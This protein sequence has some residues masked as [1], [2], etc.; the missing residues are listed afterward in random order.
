VH[1][2]QDIRVDYEHTRRLVR[3]LG[4]AGRPP[5][6]LYFEGEGHGSDDPANLRKTWDGVAGFL[7]QHLDGAS[8]A[9]AP[10]AAAE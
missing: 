7:R 4:L 10:A 6:T 9:P 1:G 3:M 2:G 5:V 8:G